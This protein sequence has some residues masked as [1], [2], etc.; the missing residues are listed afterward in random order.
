MKTAKLVAEFLGTAL[1]VVAVL[2]TGFMTRDLGADSALQLTMIAAA[3][4]A[5]LFVTISLLGPVSGAHF[6]PAVSLALLV[7]KSI[8]ASE[9][10]GYVLAQLLGGFVG[11]MVANLMF[12]APVVSMN[13]TVRF[14]AATGVSEIVATFGLVL[15]VL[16]LIHFEKANLIAGAVALWILAGHLM[17]SS[18]SFANPAVGFG[19][20]FSDS[21]AGIEVASWGMFSI[22]Q[23]AGTLLAVA[24]AATLTKKEANV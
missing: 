13:E 10:V 19:R 4:A 18:T 23:I 9:F 20:I 21:P 3:A 17:T 6:N 24:V 7:R 2:G 11:A 16:L 8:G 22:F 12:S 14:S 5:T 15:S 1:I